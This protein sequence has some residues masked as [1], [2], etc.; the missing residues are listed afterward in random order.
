MA[1]RKRDKLQTFGMR[2]LRYVFA[3]ADNGSFR[4]AAA[5]VGVQESAISR[6][7]RDLEDALG[8]ALFVRSNSGVRL[9]HAG[10]QFIARTRKGV[11]QINHAILDAASSGRGE[12]GKVRIG[13]FT[14]LA[15]GFLADLLRAFVDNNSDVRPELVEG[16]PAM[17]IAAIQ[18]HQLDVAFL[19]G[20]PQA[21]RCDTLHLWNER[22]LVAI[23]ESHEFSGRA[24]IMWSDLRDRHFIVSESDPGPEIHDYLVKHL[25]DLGRHPSVERH[26]VG[27]DNLLNLVAMNQGLTVQSEAT[28]GS[29][30]PGVIYRPLKGEVLP[31]NA[32]WLREN[33]NPALRRLLS[34]A[35]TMSRDLN[36]IEAPGLTFK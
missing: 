33:D 30:F 16:G 13:I 20:R 34:L 36:A 1:R 2:H 5:A 28:M 8:V 14:S 7:I 32:I 10:R 22:V 29:Q 11:N 12:V 23:P 19:T 6:R 17:H 15:T 24:D 31:F 3:A 26:A 9:T 25:A 27:R 35:R 21:D 4:R 18:H